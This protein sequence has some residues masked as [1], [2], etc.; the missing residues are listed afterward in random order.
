M[1]DTLNL[2]DE[3]PPPARNDNGTEPAP[4]TPARAAVAA[5]T[6]ESDACRRSASLTPDASGAP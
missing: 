6:G 5:P 2:F 4:P 1:T 3:A